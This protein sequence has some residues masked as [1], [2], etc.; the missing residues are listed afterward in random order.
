MRP[1]RGLFT[2]VFLWALLP[3]IL[4]LLGVAFSSTA[5]HQRAMRSMVA[6]RDARV[7]RSVAAALS[8]GLHRRQRIL[9]FLLD[10]MVEGTPSKPVLPALHPSAVDFDLG[11]ALLDL[12]DRRSIAESGS[13][14]ADPRDLLDLLARR[15]GEPVFLPGDFGGTP[16]IWIGLARGRWGAVGAVSF[17]ALGWTALQEAARTGPRAVVYL[18]DPE[19]TAIASTVPSGRGRS[20]QAH[21]GVAA[22]L[23]GEAGVIFHRSPE[24]SEEHVAAYAPI[25]AARWAFLIE[26]P[27]I[28]VV[29]PWLR[30][31][32]LAPLVILAITAVSLLALYASMWRIVRPLQTLGQRAIRLAWGDFEAIRSPVGGVEEIRELQRALQEMAEQ[33]RRYQRGMQDYI[34]AMTRAQEEERLR[35]ARELHDETIQSLV[36]LAQRIRMLDLALPATEEMQP[37]REQLQALSTMIRQILQGIRRL[38]RDLRPLD[39]EELGLVPALELLVRS[40]G[41]E[42]LEISL[43]VSGEE[44]RLP[45]EVE[46]AVYRI[47]Q[48]AL[49]NVIRH[50]RAQHA[51]LHLE[52]GPEG[53]TLTVEDDGQGFEPPEF[54]G[55]LALR[56]HFGL[57][58][59]YE[60]ATRLGGHFS[61]RSAPGQGTRIVVFLPGRS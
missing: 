16:G 37:A 1:L 59:M 7:A 33:I 19:G 34:A 21:G 30:Y 50:A 60:R 17:D 53:V 40:T 42:G 43:E 20:L 14:R 31:T 15:P 29:A 45:P 12:E 61:I 8:E 25:P 13:L 46:L 38:I 49:S 47:A 22:A 48:A 9:Q 56:G 23:R 44:R 55:E 41:A 11:L 2:Q 4:I 5:L 54:P 24:T 36:V 58:G 52:F 6:E 28:D 51:R 18:V 39:L 27:W 10:R 3:L 32:L 26:E 57:M 35:L